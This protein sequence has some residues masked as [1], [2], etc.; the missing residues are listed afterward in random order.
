M[1]LKIDTIEYHVAHGCNLSCQ[2]CA[3]YSNHHVRG[4][5]PTSAD[6]AVEYAN[7]S[8]RINPRL[9]ALLGGEPLLNP[10]VIGHME[11]ARRH[12]PNSKLMLV[13]NGMLLH[14]VPDLPEAAVRLDCQIEISQHGLANGYRQLFSNAMA[15]AR[16]WEAAWPGLAIVHRKS[17]TDWSRRYAIKDGKPFPFTSD[18]Q[19]AYDACQQSSC[20]QL[21]DGKLWKCPSL[22]YFA[23]LEEK[24][25]L[26]DMPEWQLFRDYKA[27]SPGA[28]DQDLKNF[29][30]G[31]QIPQCGLC[32]GR[33]IKF[34]HPNPLHI[35]ELR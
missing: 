34:N 13:T 20:T 18:E 35:V 5:M 23:K 4:S 1:K 19:Q 25:K 8:S 26:E 21:F 30:H 2:H 16:A 11:V 12:W 22:A 7:W 10:D 31:R 9:V 15:I 29:I 6:A 27:L 24:L 28:S 3:H 33:W 32:P 14:R 17:H